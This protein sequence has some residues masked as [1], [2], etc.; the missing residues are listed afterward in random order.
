MSPSS[1]TAHRCSRG[2]RDRGS[3]EIR[4]WI[5]ENDWLEARRRSAGPALLQHRHLDV[6]LDR[7]EPEVPRAPRQGAVGRRPGLLGR[8]CARA[9]ARS[10]KQISTEQIEEITRLYGDFAEGE[11]VKVFPN[12]S[13]GYQRITVERPLRLRWEVTA[14]TVE[15][16]GRHQAVG[17][18]RQTRSRRLLQPL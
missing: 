4:R 15:Q 3:R 1:S 5:I 9:S 2:R 17:E 13:F 14:D 8:R 16:L 18:A 11:K 10:A 7:D 12:E 6:L